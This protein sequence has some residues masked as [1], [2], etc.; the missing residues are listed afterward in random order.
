MNREWVSGN[1]LSDEYESGIMDFCAFALAYASRNNINVSFVRVWVV[2]ISKRSNR[3][4][5]VN[6]FC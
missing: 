1:R 2:G 3:R 4:S 6:T 5:Y